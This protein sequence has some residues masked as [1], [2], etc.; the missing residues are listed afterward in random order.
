MASTDPADR[1]IAFRRSPNAL[2]PP[3]IA[4]PTH[5]KYRPSSPTHSLRADTRH[6]PPTRDSLPNPW[7]VQTQQTDSLPSGGH[8]TPSPHQGYPTQ[9]MA[10]TDPADRL[11]PFRRTPDSLPP[12]GIAYP[13]HGKY[14]HSRQT[15]SLQADRRLPPPSSCILP[16][17]DSILCVRLLLIPSPPPFCLLQ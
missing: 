12:P 11:I 4:Y 17:P 10:S 13:T 2:P 16:N 3:G 9:P 5:G 6:P 7:Q 14:R 1:L 15:H 8:Q